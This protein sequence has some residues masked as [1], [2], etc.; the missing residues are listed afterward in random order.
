MNPRNDARGDEAVFNRIPGMYGAVRGSLCVLLRLY[1]RE[2]RTLFAA[3]M[4]AVFERAARER[5]ASGWFKFLLFALS[6]T[7]GLVRGISREW[8]ATVLRTRKHQLV[9]ESRRDELLEGLAA[10]IIEA[11]RQTNLLV[12]QFVYAIAH[13][14]F[15]KARLYAREE[16]QARERLAEMLKKHNIDGRSSPTILAGA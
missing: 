8:V 13:H 10:E 1:P 9:E 12:D 6:E 5:Q 16:Q 11:Q 3:E 4:T 2:F 14:Q 15:E 7:A